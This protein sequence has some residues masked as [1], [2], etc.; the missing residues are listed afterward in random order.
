MEIK[1]AVVAL[2]ALAQQSRLEVFRLLVKLGPEGLSAGQIAE[3]LGIPPA[4]LSFHLKE[5]THAGLIESQKVGRSVIYAVHVQGMNCLMG[6]L[7]EDCCQGRPDLCA[8]SRC[9]TSATQQPKPKQ[10][11][12]RKTKRTRASRAGARR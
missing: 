3:T 7:M 1:Q 5:L 11:Q 10:K 2:S 6:F 8:T 4:T 9:D 12:K